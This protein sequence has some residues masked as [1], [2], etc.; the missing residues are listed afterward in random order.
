MVMTA[1]HKGKRS[2]GLVQERT[3]VLCEPPNELELESGRKLGPIQIAYETYGTL[4]PEKDNVI[5][6]LH[7]LSGDHHAAGY[8][9]PDDKKPGWW[10]NFIGPGKAFDTDRYYIICSN[11]IGSCQGSTG[12]SS[13]NPETNKP[14]GLTF[15]IITIQ[16]MVNA[17]KRLLEHLE[18]D[19]LLCVA[20]GS[21]GGM[22]AL[23][24]AVSY[25]D[26]V[27]AV[28]PIATTANHSAQ[29]IAL[30]EVGRQAILADP[31]WNNGEYY[32]GEPPDRGLAVARMV[33][34]ISYLS[35]QS[36]HEKFGRKLQDRQRVSFDLLTDFQ[37]ESY[38]QYKGASFTRR[39][40]ANSYLYISKALDYF[41]LAEGY[42]SLTEAL[43]GVRSKFL[44][45]AFS[46]DWLY[47]PYQSK[48]V[49]SA[50]R[51]NGV[52]VSYCEIKSDYGHDAFL[53]ECAQQT[54]LIRDFL[55]HVPKEGAAH[56]IA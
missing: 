36:M 25:P 29:N 56:E 17:Q 39:F 38:L 12:P 2:V 33:G 50:L 22:Q 35:D 13:I 49:V 11:C 4:S 10:D 24:W 28:I 30:N 9:Q 1:I 5:L 52:S 51:Q 45:L 48:V 37:I 43:K 53:L 46:S 21:M 23:Q 31:N 40:D 16:D 32:D 19:R 27:E 3:A 8:Y 20:G 54:Q 14:Y 34:H 6:I 26:M 7:A 41:D 15:P 18:I 47:P 55:S 42:G 44:V